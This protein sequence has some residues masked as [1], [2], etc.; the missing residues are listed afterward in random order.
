MLQWITHNNIFFFRLSPDPIQSYIS[1]SWQ[2]LSTYIGIMDVVVTKYVR[3]LFQNVWMKFRLYFSVVYTYGVL[4]QQKSIWHP[5]QILFH[6]KRGYNGTV[7][8][9]VILNLDAYL[10]T[11]GSSICAFETV[12]ANAFY[13]LDCDNNISTIKKFTQSVLKRGKDF[14]QIT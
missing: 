3:F 12:S 2:C 10:A 5:M 8:I 9:S 11:I 1:N 13:I 7:R 6:I 4:T 14:L